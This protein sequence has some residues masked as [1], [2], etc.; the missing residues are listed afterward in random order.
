MA[1][2]FM[3]SLIL[4]LSAI[5]VC[6]AQ[7]IHYSHHHTK[8]DVGCLNGGRSVSL[9]SGFTFCLCPDG[10]MGS[11]CEKDSDSCLDG[12]G[13]LYR[14]S[15]SQSETGRECLPWNSKRLHAIRGHDR[16]LHLRH[17]KCRNPDHSSKPWCYVQTRFGII[18]EDCDIPRCTNHGADV[19]PVR[20]TVSQS[21]LQCGVKEESVMKVV[22]G[23]LSTVQRHPWMAA[24]FTRR[25]QSQTPV[26]MCG[27]SLIS[28]CWVLTAAHCFPRGSRTNKNQ[29]S[30]FLGKNT[31]NETDLQREQKFRVSEVIIHEHFDNTDGNFNND[32]ALLKIHSSNG[33]CARESR[34][35]KPVCI[36]DP[37]LSLDDGTSC[38]VTGYGKEREGSWHYSRHL[39]EAKVDVL[40]HDLC[41][42]KTYYGNMMTDNMLCAGSKD[43]ST[44]TCKGDSGGPLV[45]AVGGR[46]F[47]YGVVSWGEGCSRELRPGVY[48]KVSNYYHWIQEKTGLS[49]LTATSAH[50]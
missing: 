21:D 12:N 47:Q 32:I 1:R 37:E 35:V 39:R 19:S 7:K 30:V 46:A 50:L 36:P 44:D 14:G 41:S 10:Y 11:S 9:H 26:F 4:V 28:P 6:R 43:W 31:I 29:L 2:F 24:V 22:G 5:T 17:N 38:D 48:T 18:E 23:A 16:H 3:L 33:E 15:V 42:S 34:S 49:S 27:G 40:S 8:P 25:S 13:E 20:P 45:C